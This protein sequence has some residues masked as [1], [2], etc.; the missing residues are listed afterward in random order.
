M[1]EGCGNGKKICRPPRTV[2]TAMFYLAIY[3]VA[4]GYGGH[5]PTIATFGADQFGQSNDRKSKNA[6]GAF[7]CYFYF[8]LNVGS[9]FSNTVLVYFEDNG[10]WT[11]GFWLSTGSAVLAF[12]GYLL[13][14]PGYI[15]V[16]PC[17]NPI[18][19]VTQVFVATIKKLKVKA[20]DEDALY[21]V[22]GSES[23]IKGSRKILHTQ[24]YM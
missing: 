1:P 8:A 20:V 16:K 21:E 22:E 11:L 10:K 19:R 24:E 2:G 5:Q 4:F 15:Y 7:F 13:G 14:S 9:L 12:V 18:P 23:A 17:G 6:R 3:L